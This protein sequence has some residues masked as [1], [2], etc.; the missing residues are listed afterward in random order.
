ME[1]T[2]V[3]MFDNK[4]NWGPKTLSEFVS[5]RKSKDIFDMSIIAISPVGEGNWN[6]CFLPR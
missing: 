2:T 5:I 4:Q 3:D 6:P 1:Y